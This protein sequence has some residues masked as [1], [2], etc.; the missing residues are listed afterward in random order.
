MA[1]EA[2]ALSAE[3]QALPAPRRRREGHH[4]TSLA[5][6]RAFPRPQHG[7]KS[8]CI[9][10]S[11]NGFV[12]TPKHI[13]KIPCRQPGPVRSPVIRRWSLFRNGQMQGAARTR[14]APWARNL[15]PGF[16]SGRAATGAERTGRLLE[17]RGI[18]GGLRS[19]VSTGSAAVTP[20]MAVHGQAPRCRGRAGGTGAHWRVA[21]SR[22]SAPYSE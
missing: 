13:P 17:V 14:T 5:A 3:L 20:Q 15:D 12:K 9:L 6:A 1:P 8:G 7:S 10:Q 21:G 19:Y 16:R 4:R 18:P 11:R 22:S 2:I